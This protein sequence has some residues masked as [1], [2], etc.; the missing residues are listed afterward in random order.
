MSV[1][2][3][4]PRRLGCLG[5]LTRLLLC[6]AV[7]VGAV[8]AVT[9][10][11]NPWALH[12]GGR[13]TPLLYWHGT[14]TVEARDGKTYPLYVSFWPGR[15]H[16]FHGRGLREGKT[17]SGHLTGKARLCIFPGTTERMDLSGTIY[18]GYTTDTDSLLDFRLLEQR[19]AFT[20]NDPR[21]GFFDL[22]GTWHGPELVMDRPNE[23]GIRFK[24]GLSI[25][26]ATV[27]LHWAGYSEFEAACLSAGS[28][29]RPR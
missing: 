24:S 10:A 23:Q 25:D 6:A 15:P 11:L 27:R 16:G 29:D 22:A 26:H 2:G 13:P 21:R 28:Q 3:G 14:G 8:W 17:M 18:G 19:K 12:I 7:A 9:A 5:C 20:V 4:H 1:R